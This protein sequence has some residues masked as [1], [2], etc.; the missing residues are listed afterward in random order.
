MGNG[1]ILIP[2]AD[3]KDI[4][5]LKIIL[6]VGGILAEKRHL[7]RLR[8]LGKEHGL[9]DLVRPFARPDIVQQ[10]LPLKIRRLGKNERVDMVERELRKGAFLT[11]NIVQYRTQS[12]TSEEVPQG[13]SRRAFP[14]QKHLCFLCFRSH[15][16]TIGIEIRRL[17][18]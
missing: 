5:H 14:A 9:R 17:I 12:L 7:L 2:R 13:S 3:P 10:V 16:T 11:L 15:Y 6:G 4:D 8:H 1:D 18:G